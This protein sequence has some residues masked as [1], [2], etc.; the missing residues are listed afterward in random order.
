ML[1][2]RGGTQSFVFCSQI[3]L[4]KLMQRFNRSI[5]MMECY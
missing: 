4:H 1:V 3:V 2:A 5:K